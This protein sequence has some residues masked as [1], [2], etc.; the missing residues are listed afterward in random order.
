MKSL[1]LIITVSVTGVFLVSSSLQADSPIYSRLWGVNGEKWSARSRLPDFSYAGY[2][3]GEVK[4]PIKK[5]SAAIHIEKLRSKYPKYSD[6]QLVTEAVKLAQPFQTIQFGPGVYVLDDRIELKTPGVV[7]RGASDYK[8]TLKFRRSLAAIAT[9]KKVSD[10]DLYELSGKNRNSEGQSL[11]HNQGG[12]ITIGD[13]KRSSAEK[14]TENIVLGTV[15]TARKRGDTSFRLNPAPGVKIK[16]L[17]GVDIKKISGEKMVDLLGIKVT[18]SQRAYLKL[19]RPQLLIRVSNDENHTVRNLLYNNEKEKLTWLKNHPQNNTGIKDAWL[20][21]HQANLNHVSTHEGRYWLSFD[22]PFRSDIPVRSPH[23]EALLK[24]KLPVIRTEVLLYIPRVYEVGVLDFIIEMPEVAYKGHWQELG[25]NGIEV[26]REAQH[27]FIKNIIFKNVDSGIFAM[28]HGCTIDNISFRADPGRGY[29]GG[30]DR[31]TLENTVGHYGIMVGGNNNLIQD[32]IFDNYMAAHE[33]SVVNAPAGNV[34][35]G[36]RGP[37]MTLDAHGGTAH[38]NLFT[39]ISLGDRQKMWEAD[40]GPSKGLRQGA[41]NTY[42]NIRTKSSK[43]RIRFPS[44]ENRNPAQTNLIGVFSMEGAIYG[45][46]K[47]DSYNG[48]WIEEVPYGKNVTPL[49]LYKAQ[50]KKRTGKDPLY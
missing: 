28:G 50:F 36:S 45:A 23:E 4:F 12:L 29:K 49:N 14:A 18:D 35:S 32:V 16:N 40:G 22:Q 2:H 21:R 9:G 8:T 6:S 17:G 41:R 3:Q 10:K 31:D 42:W 25:Y 39:N 34:F 27:C 43:E 5:L 19:N 26:F 11:Y 20:I 30:K 46:S 44:R 1:L 37:M 13:L 24:K 15:R 7:L 33:L 38:E 47:S 48:R